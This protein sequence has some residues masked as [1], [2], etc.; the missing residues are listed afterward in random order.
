[1]RYII[2]TYIC[3]PVLSLDRFCFLNLA[4]VL[5]RWLLRESSLLRGSGPRGERHL[6]GPPLRGTTVGGHHHQPVSVLK[7]TVPVHSPSWAWTNRSN[8]GCITANWFTMV[9]TQ[10]MGLLA[11]VDSFF[12]L[13][14]VCWFVFSCLTGNHPVVWP[15]PDQKNLLI[16][17]QI[18]IFP[19]VC[20]SFFDWWFPTLSTNWMQLA[21]PVDVRVSFWGTTQ[22]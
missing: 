6:A 22:H 4:E 7:L 16:T 17:S 9:M 2:Y 5:L 15:T 3:T 14:V 19:V 11:M 20:W 21:C 18:M 1:M 13:S 10:L 12:F 8:C